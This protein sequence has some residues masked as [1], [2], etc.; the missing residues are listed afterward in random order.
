MR[1]TWWADN[2]KFKNASNQEMQ[3]MYETCFREISDVCD[4]EFTRKT[5]DSANIRFYF[6]TVAE[7]SR[8]LPGDYAALTWKNGTVWLN[9]ERGIRFSRGAIA[10]LIHEII[11]HTRY[12]NLGHVN[13]KTSIRD[14]DPGPYLSPNDV[15]LLQ[16]KAGQPKEIFYPH[17]RSEP[18]RRVRESLSK[19]NAYEEDWQAAVIFRIAEQDKKERAKKTLVVQGYLKQMR[20]ELEKLSRHS[21]EWRA[22]NDSW[23]GVPKT[24]IG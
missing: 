6:K 23:R 13:D 15:L 16:R 1:L 10:V 9:K 14:P 21:K 12:F 18:G 19:Y 5:N 3:Q 4:V 11:C 20:A 8:E 7:M 17:N 22:I 24:H 2:G